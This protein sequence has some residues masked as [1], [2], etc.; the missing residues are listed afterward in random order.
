VYYWVI[1]LNFREIWYFLLSLFLFCPFGYFCFNFFDFHGLFLGFIEFLLSLKRIQ[2]FNFG[3]DVIL[4]LFERLQLIKSWGEYVYQ[5]VHFFQH[6]FHETLVL[7]QCVFCFLYLY[8]DCLILVGLVQVL[9]KN[10]CLCW[11]VKPL[12]IIINWHKIYNN[13]IKIFNYHSIFNQ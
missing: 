4:L 6:K 13:P 8:L 7:V 11:D 5:F 10:L 12:L 9:T 1:N 3:C 2:L